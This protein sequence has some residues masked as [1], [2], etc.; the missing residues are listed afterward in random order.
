MQQS[1]PTVDSGMPDLVSSILSKGSIS[2]NKSVKDLY[3]MN[4][5][6]KKHSGSS[7]SRG[8]I[9]MCKKSPYLVVH[10]NTGLL[11][12]EV[13]ITI[14]LNL[15]WFLLLAKHVFSPRA[16]GGL[17]LGRTKQN[18]TT[19]F[20]PSLFLPSAIRQRLNFF[21][22]NRQ[23]TNKKAQPMKFYIKLPYRE[24]SLCTTTICTKI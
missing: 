6:A 20:A 21:R 1:P 24:T 19:I 11:L 2:S 10:S 3:W 14:V 9:S 8:A 5:L 7:C 22:L 4:D 15:I 13:C 12:I 23:R 16:D 18:F 17:L